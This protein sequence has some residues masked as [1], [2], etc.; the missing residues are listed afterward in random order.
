MVY[1]WKLR[2]KNIADLLDVC[3]Q[4]GN[5][6]YFQIGT[7]FM[8]QF[9]VYGLDISDADVVLIHGPALCFLHNISKPLKACGSANLWAGINATW[10]KIS[11]TYKKL[12]A[13]SLPNMLLLQYI[14]KALNYQTWSGAYIT[15]ILLS[16]KYAF[17]V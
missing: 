9:V 5:R 2:M 10:N 8:G 17:S 13:W 1:I 14:A 6:M 3:L 15:T 12:E 4:N 11:T 16:L 7:W